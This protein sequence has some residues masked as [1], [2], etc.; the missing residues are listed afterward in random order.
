VVTPEGL[1]V[2]RQAPPAASASF[3][4]TYIGPAGWAYEPAGRGG[5]AFL[6]SQLVT[7]GAG[8]RDRVALARLL[9]SYGAT[10]SHQCD[11][12]SVEITVWGP[13]DAYEPLLEVLSDVVL[14]PRFDADDLERAR[15]QAFERQ[16]R[17]TSQPES[18]AGRELLRAL[19]PAGHPYRDT[20]LGTK[21]SVTRLTRA[22]LRKFHHDH[23]TPG[24]AYLIVTG[25]PRLEAVARSVRERFRDWPVEAAPPAPTIPTVSRTTHPTQTLPMEGRTQVE[26]RYGGIS[27]ARSDPLFPEAV[28]ANEVLGGRS[29]LSRLFQRVRERAGLA[30]HASSDLEAMRWGGYWQA[31]AG[32]GPER[33][34]AADRVMQREITRLY[35][36]S[37]P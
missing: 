20:G 4:A 9:D 19:F 34:T 27:V 33:V 8:R 22:E 15:R 12:E 11:P 25:R 18:R 10:L 14:R 26:L 3:A 5:I 21:A 35:D 30:Y 13:N 2:A 37:I 36:E 6:V 17:E 16:L 1:T 31:R 29:L 24:G 23:F 32:T 28:M 7:S